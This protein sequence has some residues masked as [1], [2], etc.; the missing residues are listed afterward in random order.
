LT[1]GRVTWGVALTIANRKLW[2]KAATA[3]LIDQMDDVGFMIHDYLQWNPSR[4]EVLKIRDY[5]AESGRRGGLAKALAVAKQKPSNRLATALAKSYPDPVPDPESKSREVETRQNP[6]CVTGTENEKPNGASAPHTPKL[7]AETQ[8]VSDRIRH[9]PIFADLPAERIAYE[10]SS[11]MTAGVKLA[12]AI[13]AVDD[14]A[15]QCA[16]G[17]TY[18]EKH[19]HLVKYLRNARR[20]RETNGADDSHRSGAYAPPLPDDPSEMEAT[21][22]AS[23]ERL[24]RAARAKAEREAIEAKAKGGK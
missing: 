15:T 17:T 2:T 21:R 20:P 9:W 22:R 12:W 19:R 23:Q 6:V 18:Q 5:R 1:D 16:D 10:F 14:A 4:E 24:A 3:G 11:R 8:S 13:G 7:D